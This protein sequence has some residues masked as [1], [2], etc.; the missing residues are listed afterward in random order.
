MLIDHIGAVLYPEIIWFRVIGRISFPLY[1]YL[2]AEGAIHTK[3]KLKYTQRLLLFAFISQIPYMLAFNTFA[4]NILF[5][6]VVGLL[7]I[8]PKFINVLILCGL[9]YF[10]PLDYGTF[11]VLL[12]LLFTYFRTNKKA[13]SIVI[14]TLLAL[15]TERYAIGPSLQ[16]LALFGVLLAFYLPS[17]EAVKSFT[18]NRWFFY[19][20]YPAHLVILFIFSFRY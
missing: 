20:F 16:P 15:Y 2:I 14:V 19:W 7:F 10:L 3:N 13:G 9:G 1:A 5:T 11:G 17:I 18:V 6:L 8:K 4:P 12:P